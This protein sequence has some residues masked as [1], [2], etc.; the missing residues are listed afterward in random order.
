MTHFERL[1]SAAD[2]ETFALVRRMIGRETLALYIAKGIAISVGA[3]VNADV[4]AKVFNIE[5][6]SAY[7]K[8]SKIDPIK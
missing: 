8:I 2:E 7:N 4:V 1:L 6:E 5:V 3:K